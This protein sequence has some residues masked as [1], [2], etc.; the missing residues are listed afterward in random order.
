M[1]DTKPMTKSEVNAY[2]AEKTGMSLEEAKT[3]ASR[4]LQKL[5]RWCR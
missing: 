4:F 5:K 1:S 3:Q 2:M